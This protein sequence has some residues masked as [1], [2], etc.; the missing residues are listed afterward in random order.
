MFAHELHFSIIFELKN[1]ASWNL[2]QNCAECEQVLGGRGWSQPSS[3]V[4][5]AVIWGQL[6]PCGQS[7]QS[8]DAHPLA[9]LLS[10]DLS[11]PLG[12]SLLSDH[13]T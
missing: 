4:C 3:L 1:K 5:P 11:Q 10:C 13:W 6:C 8:L 7:T 2:D 12:C 9:L